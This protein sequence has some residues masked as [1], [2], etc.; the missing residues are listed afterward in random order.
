[1]IRT[2]YFEGPNRLKAWRIDGGVS[3]EVAAAISDPSESMFS[4]VFKQLNIGFPKGDKLRLYDFVDRRFE[5]GLETDLPFE[6]MVKVSR[7]CSVAAL[8]VQA[9]EP[10]L[11]DLKSSDDRTDLS[12]N[13][14]GG[15]DS[16]A[17][18]SVDG[19]KLAFFDAKDHPRVLHVFPHK[20][21]STARVE[22]PNGG[23]PIVPAGSAGR[24]AV[25]SDQKGQAYIQLVEI[26][27]DPRYE[28][29][30]FCRR[31][32]S[33][34]FKLRFC[35]TSMPVRISPLLRLE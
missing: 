9:K 25:K 26:E 13:V 3:A 15:P 8:F 18:L 33:L 20:V 27:P 34:Y 19:R 31:L 24:M 2:E 28:P 6:S 21:L 11:L 32:L 23:C 12:I 4:C 16:F 22:L 29:P 5:P 1:M 17:S 35:L 10:D 30:R 14:Q 7:D